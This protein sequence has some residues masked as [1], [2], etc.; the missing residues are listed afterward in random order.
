MLQELSDGADNQKGMDMANE[1]NTLL[2]T[3]KEGLTVISKEYIDYKSGS[4]LKT[5][6]KL[7]ECDTITGATC[8]GSEALMGMNISLIGDDEALF[9][10]KPLVNPI[11]SLLGGYL[12]HEQPLYGNFLVVKHTEQGDNADLSNEDISLVIDEIYGLIEKFREQTGKRI[13]MSINPNPEYLKGE[14]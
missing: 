11:A 4:Y 14:P 8:W 9:V 2:I 13:V 1:K 3:V 7:I 5:M 10:E 12:D 6:H